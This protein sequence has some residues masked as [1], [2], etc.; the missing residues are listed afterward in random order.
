[1]RLPVL[2]TVSTIGLFFVIFIHLVPHMNSSLWNWKILDVEGVSFIIGQGGRFAVPF[3]FLSVGYYYGKSLLR[4]A[5]PFTFL[6]LYGR[7]LL[8]V[9]I[10][11]NLIYAITPPNFFHEFAQFRILSSMYGQLQN[12]YDWLINNNISVI[13][14]GTK[15]HLWFIMASLTGLAITSLF[16]KYNIARFLVPFG[17]VL[18]LI[19][20]LG[21]SYSRSSIGLSLPFD[22]LVLLYSTIFIAVGRRLSMYHENNKRLALSFFF[23]GALMHFAEI[24]YLKRMYDLDAL[25]H[26]FLLGTAFWGMGAFLL[27]LEYP[28]AG[29]NS[30]LEKI[31]KLTLGIYV[32]HAL[33]ID[34]LL[35]TRDLVTSLIWDLFKPVFVL[36]LSYGLCQGLTRNRIL[37]KFLT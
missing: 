6:L 5:D 7:K 24:F 33:I 23:G 3:F 34:A 36:L 15:R 13:L 37:A 27:C 12:T 19:G 16:C 32:S 18:Y 31:G 21:D 26:N 2:D 4:G 35:P 28:N 14:C 8:Y 20:L 11:W 29:R 10:S 17:I 22:T 9:Y 30:F 1:M 25:G